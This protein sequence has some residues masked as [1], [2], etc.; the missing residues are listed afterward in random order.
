[1]T[2]LTYQISK[3]TPNTAKLDS[4]FIVMGMLKKRFSVSKIVNKYNNKLASVK[5]QLSMHKRLITLHYVTLKL[6][7]IF[8]LKKCIKNVKKL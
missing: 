3:F 7:S 6:D 4:I 5:I 1:M 8:K 2:A